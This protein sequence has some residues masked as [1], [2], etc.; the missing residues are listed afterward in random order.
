M[1]GTPPPFIDHFSFIETIAWLQGMEEVDERAGI[2]GT[3]KEC[4]SQVR[5]LS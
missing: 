5:Q 1:K 2:V 4:L 3:G